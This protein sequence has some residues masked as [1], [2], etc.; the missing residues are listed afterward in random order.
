M[1]FLR[2]DKFKCISSSVAQ[3]SFVTQ[4]CLRTSAICGRIAGSNWSRPVT[5]LLNSSEKYS[6]PFG[7]FY[8]CAFQKMSARLAQI[9]R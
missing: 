2:L 6:A 3:S 1:R 9:S 4:G 5:K 7:L 8:E